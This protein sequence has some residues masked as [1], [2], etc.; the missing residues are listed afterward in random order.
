M[1]NKYYT[2]KIEEFHAEFEY[3]IYVNNNWIKRTVSNWDILGEFVIDSIEETL[4]SIGL[5]NTRVKFL[6]KEDIESFGFK[7]TSDKF[8]FYT[9]EKDSIDISFYSKD[10]KINSFIQIEDCEI[11]V[12]AGT[13][14]NKS[15]LKKILQMLNI[16]E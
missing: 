6:D 7:C 16:I 2:P 3:E 1:E 11:Q 12:F 8:D 10:R 14:K 9:F 15:E 13:V 4:F 5:Q